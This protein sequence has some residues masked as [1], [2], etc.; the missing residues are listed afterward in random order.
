MKGTHPD[1]FI[2]TKEYSCP[3]LRCGYV[4]DR[5]LKLD[6]HLGSHESTDE[7]CFVKDYYEICEDKFEGNT[8]R[9]FD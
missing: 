1:H 6:L 3:K 4:F 9:F 2:P 8:A 7:R 5:K